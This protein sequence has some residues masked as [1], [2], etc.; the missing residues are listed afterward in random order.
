MCGIVGSN[1]IS[2]SFKSSIELLSHRGP[3]NT[4]Y[5]EYK[6]NHFQGNYAEACFGHTRLAIIDLDNEANQ[7][8]EFDNIIITFNGEIYNYQELIKNEKLECKTQSDTEVLI[9]LYQKYDTKFLNKLEGMFS[10]CIYDKDKNS[11][12]CARDRFG[13]KPFYYYFKNGKFIYAS[14]IKSIIQVLQITPE[15][16]KT[17]L[18]EYL[19][20]MSAIN[21][22]FYQDIN[23][24]QAGHSFTIDNNLNLEIKKY[25]DICNIETKYY[26]ENLILEDIEN[27]LFL[28]V[29]SRMIADVPIVTLLSGGIDSSLIS[30]LYAKLNNNPIDTFCIGYDEYTQYSELPYAK[31]V[32]QHIQSNHHEIIMT[33]K[34]FLENIDT[35]LDYMDEPIGDTASI[36]TYFLTQKITKENKKVA[37]SGEGSDEIF[38]GYESY[39]KMLDLYK[40]NKYQI[41]G[42]IPFNLT[43]EWEYNNRIYNSQTLYRSKGE[44]FTEYQKQKLFTAYETKDYLKGYKNDYEPEKWMSYIDFKVWIAEVLMTKIDRM[45][46]ANGLEL[47]APFLDHKL[48]EYLFAVDSR[49][50]TG[51]TNKYLLKKIA[52]KY[53]PKEIVHRQKK[54]FSYPFMEWLSAE[55]GNELY[56]TIE[57]VNRVLQIFNMD[58][59]KFL[60]NQSKEKKFIHHFWNIYLFARWY[61][62]VYL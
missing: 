45:S 9:R 16:N 57:E 56:V 55:Y 46:M 31:K 49:I 61:K 5:L 44:I 36:P 10:F 7:P 62:R 40:I 58:F 6:N 48:V 30:A 4:G 54:G 12:F 11:F 24:L 19:S 33:R 41:K 22:T 2:S 28:S 37:L 1:F 43:K 13:K 15:L 20:F 27:L 25:Y 60:Y 32:A 35:I 59:V 53:L 51:N 21:C 52:Q 14:E 47:R 34:D 18:Y 17:A 8:M 42:D 38:L 50:K 23:K 39:F 29:K 26:D 3:D